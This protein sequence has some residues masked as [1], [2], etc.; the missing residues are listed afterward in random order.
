VPTVLVV[1]DSAVDR[2]MAGGLLEQGLHCDVEYAA[3]GKEALQM[4]AAQRP[5][6][7]LADIRMPEMNGLE[8]MTAVK[9]DFPRV[10]VILMTAVGSEDLAA[11]ALRCGAA[12]YVPKSNLNKDLLSTVRRILEAADE[13]RAH[14]Q[15]M[16]YL[17]SSES[18]FMLCNDMALIKALASHLQQMLRCMPLGDETERVRVGI[19]LEEA[20]L[21]AYYHG[22][23]ELGP[24]RAA[25]DREAYVQLANQRSYEAPYRQR[26]IRVHAQINRNEAVFVI[27][28]DGKGFDQAT[29]AAHTDLSE[30]EHAPGRGINLMC[31]IMDEVTF[32]EAGNEVTLIKRRAPQDVENSADGAG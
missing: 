1:D 21:N 22:N 12:S 25:P 27:S 18:R 28:D 30:S 32:N 3:N 11:E 4:M 7:L 16:H 9:S 5:D 31:S 20:M 2:R 26:R 6:L 29:T 17:D 10:P 15:L 23:L 13:D 14:P 24:R 8:L 19:A